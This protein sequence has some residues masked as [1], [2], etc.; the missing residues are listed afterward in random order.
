MKKRTN[1]IFLA[2]VL[3]VA[4]VVISI[5]DNSLN[6]KSKHQLSGPAVKVDTYTSNN[7]GVSFRY[8]DKD[9][10]EAGKQTKVVET[11]N[12]IYV[13]VVGSN[14]KTDGQSITIIPKT[15]TL[16]L[17][18]AIQS[19][20]LS[21]YPNC[22]LELDTPPPF[23]GSPAF[24]EDYQSAQIHPAGWDTLPSN[25][26][27]QVHEAFDNQCPSA[28]FED[29]GASYFLADAK[30]PDKFAYIAL[31]QYSIMGSTSQNGWQDTV[32]FQ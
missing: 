17:S 4:I 25:A 21:N 29:G 27:L 7:L 22:K 23:S 18:Q 5:Y 28:Y 15:P 9:P 8:L 2:A 6:G 19:Q 10:S 12:T 16:T 24:P 20:L 31:G 32:E 26:G 30:V 3:I 13:Y 14:P 11:G 1:T